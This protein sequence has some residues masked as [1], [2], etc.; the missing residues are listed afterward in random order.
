MF[1]QAYES[2]RTMTEANIQ[3]QQEVF[4]KWVGMMTGVPAPNGAG[5]RPRSSHPSSN[6]E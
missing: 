5:R 2:L 1:E 3:M 6:C 4:K